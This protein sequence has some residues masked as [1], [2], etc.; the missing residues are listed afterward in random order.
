MDGQRLTIH[1][2]RCA[3]A[4]L[5]SSRCDAC[6][7]ACPTQAWSADA[8]GLGFDGS[9]CDGCGLCVV[10]CPLEALAIGAPAVLI[11]SG[12]PRTLWLACHRAPDLPAGGAGQ[13]TCLHGL[14]VQWLLRQMQRH[15]AGR[16][17]CSY[18]DCRHCSHQPP[19]AQRLQSRWDDWARRQPDSA[20]QP[21]A[22]QSVP[23]AEWLR[24]TLG[25]GAPDASRRRFFAR[26]LEPSLPAA[27]TVAHGRLTSGRLDEVNDSHASLPVPRWDLDWD[28][29]RC[30]WCKVCAHL[31]PTGA[32]H[33]SPD[34]AAPALTFQPGRCNGCGLCSDGCDQSA[35]TLR[36]VSSAP[37]EQRF[38][39]ERVQCS[40]CQVDYWR[41]PGPAR[42]YPSASPPPEAD[43]PVCPTCRQ[44]K[45]HF[46]ARVVQS[47]D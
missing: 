20:P 22:L 23:S 46:Q 7:Q 26:W 40:R 18:G 47:P 37:G 41:L 31:C 28:L 42:Q 14:P 10:A 27:A 21:A 13:V 15:Q 11:D 24:R 4:R 35:L 17:A 43:R 16:I 25:L 6:V 45:P 19:P 38:A 29:D 5:T 12:L 34:S 1:A 9:R 39:L 33:Q 2:E 8:Q 3:H 30:T 32:I 36:P 44:G